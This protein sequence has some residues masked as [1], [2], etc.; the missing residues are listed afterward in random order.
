MCNLFKFSWIKIWSS[1]SEKVVT[2][3]DNGSVPKTDMIW[4]KII[5]A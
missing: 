3:P 5:D 2:G 4:D 1:V